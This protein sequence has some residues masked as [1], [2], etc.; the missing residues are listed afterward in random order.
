[1][2]QLLKTYFGYDEFRP[3]QEE[4]IDNVMAGKKRLWRR[5]VAI[6]DMNNTEYI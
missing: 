6:D 2:K 1:M 4:V 3:L 5:V